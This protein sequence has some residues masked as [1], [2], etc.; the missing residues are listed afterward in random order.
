MV[1]ADFEDGQQQR[2]FVFEV[3]IE[4]GGGEVDSGGNVFHGGRFVAVFLEDFGCREDD[5]FS[6]DR[7]IRWFT[8][9]RSHPYIK[10]VR[11]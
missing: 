2:I 4:T 11:N 1:E 5:R 7:L 3:V 6:I 10:S 8:R 9:H